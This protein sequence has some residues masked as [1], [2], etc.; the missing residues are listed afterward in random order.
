MGG[1]VLLRGVN[2]KLW[3]RLRCSLLCALCTC[4]GKNFGFPR[5]T[6]LKFVIH[7]PKTIPPFSGRLDLEAKLLIHKLINF[8]HP[9]PVALGINKSPGV[10]I[11]IRAND[12]FSGE[13]R[14]SVKVKEV[15]VG[16]LFQWQILGRGP[17]GRP[18]LTFIPNWGQKGRKHFFGDRPP[19]LSQDLDDRSPLIWGLD[20]PLFLCADVKHNA[21]RTTTLF[22]INASHIFQHS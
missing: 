11:S 20:P 4:M 19:P 18:P 2:D 12:S 1:I 5:L 22:K 15:I 16:S 9:H 8:T 14:G 13:K 10:F 6:R 7:T 3:S 17:G 21:T